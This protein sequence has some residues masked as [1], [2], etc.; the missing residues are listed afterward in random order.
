MNGDAKRPRLGRP[1]PSSALARV[2]PG[3]LAEPQSP[4]V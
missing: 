2:P 1:D 4:F 3:E